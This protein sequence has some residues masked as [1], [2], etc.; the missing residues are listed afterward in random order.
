M[1]DILV[2]V[3]GTEAG[4]AALR[5]AMEEAAV[6]SAGVTAVHVWTPRT[7]VGPIGFAAYPVDQEQERQAHEVLDA[8]LSRALARSLVPA[9]A[10]QR[11][12]LPSLV[13][14]SGHAAQALEERART[15]SMLV[16]GRRHES[17]LSRAVFGS[18]VGA[19]LHHVACPVVVVPS[20]H[21]PTPGAA[22]RIVVGVAD[23][24]ASDGALRW[25]A[26]TALA[27]GRTLVP[28]LVR[29][30]GH[31][32]LSGEGWPDAAT[33][34][35]SALSNLTRH[36]TAAAPALHGALE[37]EVLVGDAGEELVRFTSGDDLLVVGSRAR[38]AL[39]G[40]LLGSSSNYVA[41]HATCPVVVVRDA[42]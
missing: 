14:A 30:T 6:T 31:G 23:G 36:S 32:P 41:R 5:W 1:D 16:L 10:A 22:G 28:V 35:A 38:G 33:L 2:G 7:A 12:V 18:V 9:G 27:H 25:A 17:A 13:A 40:W 37:P 15:A 26:A 11:Q 29:P 24:Q 21:E 20:E 19:A 4:D 8:A 3:D 42:R 39:A 34:D